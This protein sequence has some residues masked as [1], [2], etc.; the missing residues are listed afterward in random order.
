MIYAPFSVPMILTH[1]ILYVPAEMVLIVCKPKQI[2]VCI[3]QIATFYT[4]C[5]LQ[6]VVYSTPPSVC[7]LQVSSLLVLYTNWFS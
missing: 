5:T 4:T 2:T 6:R 7:I 1:I 3:V